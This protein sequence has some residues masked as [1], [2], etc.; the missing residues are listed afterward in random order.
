MKLEPFPKQS[1]PGWNYFK[2]LRTKWEPV[3][4]NSWNQVRAVSKTVRTELVLLTRRIG[5]K[6]KCFSEQ[7]ES[8][9]DYVQNS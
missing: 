9:Y 1:E 3:W 6:L 7:L 8:I 4:N 5:A 2:T